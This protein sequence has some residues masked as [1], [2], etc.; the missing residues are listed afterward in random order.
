[1]IFPKSLAL[2]IALLALCFA[3]GLLLF[4]YFQGGVSHAIRSSMVWN[5]SL[6]LYTSVPAG[7]GTYYLNADQLDRPKRAA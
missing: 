7:A 1:M 4:V 5:P 3:A 6:C 2:W